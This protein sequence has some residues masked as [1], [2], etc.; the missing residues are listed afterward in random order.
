MRWIPRRAWPAVAATVCLAASALLLL[1]AFDARAWGQKVTRDDLRFQAIHAH[2]GLWRSPAVIPGD[3]AKWLLG[4]GD[5]LTYRHGLQIYWHSRIGTDSQK[6]NDVTTTRIDA[7]DLLDRISRTAATR[8]ERSNAANL[9]GVLTIT[10]P[11]ADTESQTRTQ[12]LQRAA[13]YF[14]RAIA[15]S[16]ANSAAKENLELVLRLE[17]RDQSRFGRDA[18]AGFGSGFGRGTGVVGSGF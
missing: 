7:A 1:V 11:L 4:L 12:T 2:H 10:T 16:Q 3:P 13:G 18:K 14:R 15:Q 6:R 5:G 9:L 8:T 17:K